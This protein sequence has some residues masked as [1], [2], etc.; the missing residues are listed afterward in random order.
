MTSFGP[1]AESRRPAPRDGQPLFERHRIMV[2]ATSSGAGPSAGPMLL[3]AQVALHHGPN[4]GPH[5]PGP[6][7]S[8]Q[9]AVLGMDER[10]VVIAQDEIA[11]PA[12]GW[13]FR[14]SGLWVD[15]VCERP[16]EHWSYGLEA[17]ALALDDPRELLG[18]GYGDRVPLGWEFEFVAERPGTTS[19]VDPQAR[20]GDGYRQRG[21]AEGLL[22]SATGEW[23][24]EGTATRH[25]LW[26]ARGRT[27]RT[28]VVR[29]G[30]G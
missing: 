24:F 19:P 20:I 11:V 22:L 30:I 28:G 18:R 10:P 1:D 29:T 4:D 15:F 26:G 27:G 5:R 8:F 21:T 3:A 7:A 16:M 13:E 12:R 25:H 2:R 14:A 17:F 23:A 9:C 6:T